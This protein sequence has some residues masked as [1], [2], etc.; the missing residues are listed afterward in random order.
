MESRGRQT[1]E[2][3]NRKTIFFDFLSRVENDQ[4]NP[5]WQ[6]EIRDSKF[7]S[8]SLFLSFFS[9]SVSHSPFFLD[10][11][12]FSLCYLFTFVQCAFCLFPPHSHFF[13]FFYIFL[14]LFLSVFYYVST[15]IFFSFSS[16]TN[17]L[18]TIILQFF[19][20]FSL[21][22]VISFHSLFSYF[23]F[24]FLFFQFLFLLTITQ[25]NNVSPHLPMKNPRS[26]LGDKLLT[27]CFC[28]R[29]SSKV[30]TFPTFFPPQSFCHIKFSLTPFLENL[31]IF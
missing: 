15:Y 11:F 29:K 13:L 12:P 1:E 20:P 19:Y 5:A 10:V 9:F 14:Y 31:N 2:K 27:D 30:P 26:Q 7:N 21:F 18:F 17:Y 24:L 16:I 22:A 3:K 23:L 28:R 8:Q 25:A 6:K 4:P